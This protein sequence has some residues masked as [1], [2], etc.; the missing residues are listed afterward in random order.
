LKSQIEWAEELG[1]NY[2]A[3]N[4][5]LKKG[6]TVKDSFETPVRITKRSK[7]LKEFNG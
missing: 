6:R 7:A 1:L 2:S 4:L 3:V 5:R